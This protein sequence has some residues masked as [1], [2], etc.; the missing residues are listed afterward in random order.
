V[1]PR[2]QKQKTW[3]KNYEFR[4]RYG[5]NRS[6]LLA[7]ENAYQREHFRKSADRRIKAMARYAAYKSARDKRAVS[8]ASA[9]EILNI[10]RR[11][12]ELSVS[13]GIPHEVDHIIPLRGI[14]VSGLHVE[15][16][17]QVIT[18]AENRAKR[19]RFYDDC[20]DAQCIKG[21]RHTDNHE[22]PK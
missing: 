17:L 2:R 21:D 14:N 5:P 16:N 7:Q 8:W 13:T 3:Q 4:S 9:T 18:K 19:N 6:E 1:H 15:N 12:N 20:D 11:A 22:P 10:Y